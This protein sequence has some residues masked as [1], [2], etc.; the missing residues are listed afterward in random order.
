MDMELLE[1]IDLLPARSAESFAEW[2][3]LHLAVEVITRDRSTLYPDGV[4][5]GSLTAIQITASLSFGS[6][7]EQGSRARCS[8][9][10]NRCP[11]AI[12]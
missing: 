4:R 2:L 11:K 5:Q 9:V 6:Q 8:A 3:E 7:F 12:G 1:V 10:A